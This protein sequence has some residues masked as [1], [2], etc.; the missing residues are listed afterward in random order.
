MCILSAEINELAGISPFVKVKQV[1]YDYLLSRESLVTS[2]LK[3][4]QSKD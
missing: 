4:T 1:S 3:K 2:A